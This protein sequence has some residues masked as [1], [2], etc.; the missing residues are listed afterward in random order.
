MPEKPLEA[1]AALTDRARAWVRERMAQSGAAGETASEGVAS[2]RSP[3]AGRSREIEALLGE[4]TLPRPLAAQFALHALEAG[5]PRFVGRKDALDR[6][7]LALDAWREQHPALIA[8]IGPQGCGLTSLLRQLETSLR[9]GEEIHYHAL[10]ARPITPQ[11]A[12]RQCGALFGLDVRPDRIDELVEQINALPPR[13]VLLDNGHYLA[14][15]I[16]G[17]TE[18][19]RTLGAIMVAT[20][21]RH[22]W[23]FACHEQAWRRLCYVHQTDRYFQEIVEIDPFDRDMLGQAVAARFAAADF[24]LAQDEDAETNAPVTDA[25]LEELHKLSGGFPGSAFFHLLRALEPVPEGAGLRLCRFLPFDYAALKDLVPAELF[26]LA[27]IA[28]HGALTAAEH[29]VLFRLR[30]QESQMLLQRLRGL[31]LLERAP[32]RDGDAHYRL[33]PQHAAAIISRLARANYLY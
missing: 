26:T 28:V 30:E 9:P 25:R 6:L 14:C 24:A 10:N 8:L 17:A 29:Q 22:Q 7:R 33:V 15:R 21:E 2:L 11:E 5:D 23:V 16:M 13:L 3:R 32:G 27:E 20:Q 18:T 12:M 19:I 1:I 4:A 31:C